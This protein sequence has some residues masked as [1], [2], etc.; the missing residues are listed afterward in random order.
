[1]EKIRIKSTIHLDILENYPNSFH[2]KEFLKIFRARGLHNTLRRLEL[3][4]RAPE[5]SKTMI[6]E[7]FPPMTA[8]SDKDGLIL[9]SIEIEGNRARLRLVTVL[10]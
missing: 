5:I 6:R 8:S 4:V 7:R 2:L 1:M 3:E 10:A 9:E